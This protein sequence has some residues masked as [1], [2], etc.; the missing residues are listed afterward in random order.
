LEEHFGNIYIEREKKFWKIPTS[1]L[2]VSHGGGGEV[3]LTRARK[4]HN[5]NNNILRKDAKNGWQK[6]APTNPI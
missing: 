5:N 1:P 6:Y 2:V 3:G 4:Q